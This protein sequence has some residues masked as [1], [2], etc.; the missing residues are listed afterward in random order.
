MLELLAGVVVATAALAAVLEPLLTA[1]RRGVAPAAPADE[2][3]VVDLDESDSPKVR[4]LLALRE[5]EFDRATGKLS[6]E[7]Y[8]Q[9]KGRYA[10]EAVAAMRAEAAGAAQAAAAAGNDDPAEA[11]IR[12][13]SVARE[14]VC[15]T[16]GPR[17]E[18]GARFCSGCG[19]RVA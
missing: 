2:P 11:A 4:A 10:T 1:P 5:I 17:P 14:R 19:R 15:P 16:C 13:A 3:D 7:D 9:L 6:D 12:R 8:A 18:A